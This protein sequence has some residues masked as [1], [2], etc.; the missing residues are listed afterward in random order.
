[1]NW[2]RLRYGIDTRTEVL[3]IHKR[4]FTTVQDVLD[5]INIKTCIINVYDEHGKQLKPGDIVQ[6]MRM[7]KVI[8][9]PL[10]K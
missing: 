7:Y 5:R 1:M 8:R 6:E 10:L 4:N 3:F 9:K 2:I